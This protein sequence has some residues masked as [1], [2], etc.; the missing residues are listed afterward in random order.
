MSRNSDINQWSPTSAARSIAGTTTF[1]MPVPYDILVKGVHVMG[2][3]PAAADGDTLNVILDYAAFDAA[4]S[5]TTIAD[6][7]VDEYNDTDDTASL[8]AVGG[9]PDAR[10]VGAADWGTLSFPGTRVPGNS[11]LRLREVWAGTVTDGQVQIVVSYV[12]LNDTD[13]TD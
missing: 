4:A 7:S 9:T 2:I 5:Y 13:N 12:V 1:Y 11:F 6:S 8:A 3:N 10:S